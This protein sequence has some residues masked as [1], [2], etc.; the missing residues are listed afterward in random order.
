MSPTTRAG[1]LRAEETIAD[2]LN[3][4]SRAGAA[5]FAD[6]LQRVADDAM[7]TKPSPLAHALQAQATAARTA[8]AGGAA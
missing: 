5:I 8:L 4:G 7:A 2:L 6:A 3:A 1:M